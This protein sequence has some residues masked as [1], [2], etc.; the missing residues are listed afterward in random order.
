MKNILGIEVTKPQKQLKIFRGVSGS[1]KS[2]LAKNLSKWTGSPVHSTDTL[3]EQLEIG[4]RGFFQD[5]IEKNNFTPLHKMHK[6]CLKYAKKSIDDGITPVIIDNTN[7][8]AWEPKEIVMYALQNGYD[9]KNIHIVDIGTA[10]FSAEELFKRNQ[11]GV[12][13]DKIQ[14]MID[15]YNS[16][17]ELTLEKIINAKNPHDRVLYSGI[18]LD[19]ESRAKLLE[20]CKNNIPEGFS[21]FNH[22]MTIIFGKELPEDLKEDLGK[23]IT[24]TVTH[25]GVMEGVVAVNAIGYEVLTDK[26]AHITVA[27]DTKNNKTPKLAGDITYWVKFEEDFNVKGIIK[28]IRA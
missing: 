13:L 24:L 12:P 10:G 8:K 26:P 21:I 4:Y 17:G 25:L 27:V 7:I 2:T 18:V 5:M 15:S 20:K 9:D 11:H 14:S 22:H 23:E 28:E 3:I 16:V 6:L 1:G 19:E